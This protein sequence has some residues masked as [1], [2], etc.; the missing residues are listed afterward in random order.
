MWHYEETYSNLIYQEFV[1]CVISI[2]YW[3]KHVIK[4]KDAIINLGVFFRPTLL[5]GYQWHKAIC[6]IIIMLVV[7]FKMFMFYTILYFIG[8]FLPNIKQ[9]AFTWISTLP[10]KNINKQGT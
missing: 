7:E 3:D 1:P 9:E 5:A 8:F 6:I 4:K 10:P 2:V